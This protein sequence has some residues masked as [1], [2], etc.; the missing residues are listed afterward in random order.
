V[1]I[2]EHFVELTREASQYSFLE[3]CNA[4]DT[5]TLGYFHALPQVNSAWST[6]FIVQLKGSHDTTSHSCKYTIRKDFKWISCT[7]YLNALH[8][9]YQR[10]NCKKNAHNNNNRKGVESGKCFSILDNQ[11]LL[12][13]SRV[14]TNPLHLA[15]AILARLTY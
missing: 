4:H 11:N 7:R 12:L 10:S 3:Y 9:L 8:W 13:H 6:E 15:L 1:R 5:T 14:L 2:P